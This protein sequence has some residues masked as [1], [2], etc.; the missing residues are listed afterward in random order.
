MISECLKNIKYSKIQRSLI[1]DVLIK[2]AADISCYHVK[3]WPVNK[4]LRRSYRAFEARILE[5]K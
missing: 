4:A 3:Q 5:Q 1:F 2:N